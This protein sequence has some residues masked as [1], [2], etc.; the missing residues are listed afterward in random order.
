MR[1]PVCNKF[2]D[3]SELT[4]FS[5]ECPADYN[6]CQGTVGY[7]DNPNNGH[8]F[9]S[10]LKIASGGDM[11]PKCRNHPYVPNLYSCPCF[12]DNCNYYNQVLKD[13]NGDPVGQLQPTIKDTA[14]LAANAPSTQPTTKAAGGGTGIGTGTGTGTGTGGAGGVGGA[15]VFDPNAPPPNMQNLDVP[16]GSGDGS[17]SDAPNADAKAGGATANN[18]SASATAAASTLRA[19]MFHSLVWLL[20]GYVFLLIIKI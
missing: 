18:G 4:Q 11:T 9:R 8:A 12:F 13:A 15:G 6:A 5:V 16:A 10:C 1:N 19:T 3:T 20:S 17:A 14:N 2:A 7:V